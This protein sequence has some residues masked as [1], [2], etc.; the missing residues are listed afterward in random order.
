MV[1]SV[2]A[3][4][5]GI[6]KWFNDEKGCGFICRPDDRGD[7]YVVATQLRNAGE[8]CLYDGQEVEFDAVPGERGVEA[9][10]VV[11]LS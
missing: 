1:I 9:R 8:G 10:D 5:R 6:V 7:A 2:P 11:A 3:R 4:E